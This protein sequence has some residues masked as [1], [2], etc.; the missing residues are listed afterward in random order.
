MVVEWVDCCGSQ[1]FI[2]ALGTNFYSEKVT[3]FL[4][5]KWPFPKETKG[6]WLLEKQKSQFLIA[7]MFS[8][9]RIET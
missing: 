1:I 8:I 3:I 4:A 5:Q 9:N 7:Y 6:F 2:V